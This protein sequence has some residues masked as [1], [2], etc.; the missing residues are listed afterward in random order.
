MTKVEM[1]SLVC[2]DYRCVI[3]CST[4][5]TPIVRI[6]AKAFFQPLG[7]EL[8]TSILDIPLGLWEALEYL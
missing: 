1:S 2:I 8:K 3:Y 7:I 4:E 6:K 5:H